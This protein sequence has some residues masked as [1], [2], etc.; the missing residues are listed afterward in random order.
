MRKSNVLM[1]TFNCCAD[2][3][4]TRKNMS[5]FY[6]QYIWGETLTWYLRLMPAFTKAEALLQKNFDFLE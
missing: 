4:L 5:L 6:S 3:M 1:G 2:F